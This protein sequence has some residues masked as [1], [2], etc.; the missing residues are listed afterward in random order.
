MAEN[1]EPNDPGAVIGRRIAR[2]IGANAAKSL[3]EPFSEQM[4][5]L[6]S[7]TVIDSMNRVERD[8]TAEQRRE[9]QRSIEYATEVVHTDNPVTRSAE[10]MEKSEHHLAEMVEIVKATRELTEKQVL[11]AAAAQQASEAA[12][13]E[14]RTTAR[15]S[16]VIAWVSLGVAGCSLVASLVLGIIDL[17]R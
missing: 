13:A 2:G 3:T 15:T 12:Q 17:T 11:I 1:R 10:A 6:I 8:V 14:T 4:R 7:P 5:K 9:L 16:M